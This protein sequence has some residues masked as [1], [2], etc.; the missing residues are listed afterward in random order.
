MANCVLSRIDNDRI[1]VVP[2][3]GNGE[4]IILSEADCMSQFGILPPRDDFHDKDLAGLEK[5]KSE[6]QELIK[7]LGSDYF[8]I[9]GY[10]KQL[11][12]VEAKIKAL[13][14]AAF[15]GQQNA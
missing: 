15:V 9:Y 4:I 3:V 1:A 5:L 14:G 11:E 2:T 13:N 6:L 10:A 8:L 7:S 12:S